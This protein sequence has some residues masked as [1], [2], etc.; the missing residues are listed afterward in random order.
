MA[1][2]DID[3]F[4]SGIN[5]RG[6]LARSNRFKVTITSMGGS[7]APD[8]KAVE[9]LCTA[10]T[11]PGRTVATQETQQHRETWKA[12][13]TV[14]DD[15]VTMTFLLTNDF[16]ARTLIEGWMMKVFNHQRY[17]VGYKNDYAGAVEITGVNS[18]SATQTYGVTLRNAYPTSMSAIEMSNDNEN[19]YA[20]MNVTFAYD[21]FDSTDFS[22]GRVR[23]GGAFGINFSIGTALGVISA[24]VP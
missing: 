20:T 18:S 4:K 9:L 15:E 14:I 10:V 2:V 17:T 16:Y 22:G 3:S 23:S 13:Y 8:N 5:S 19:G 1:V 11:I 7:S 24:G 12:P 21:Y 6:G